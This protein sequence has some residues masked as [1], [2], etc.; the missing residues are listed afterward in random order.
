MAK[1][2]KIDDLLKDLDQVDIWDMADP[3][4]QAFWEEFFQIE[5]ML[6]MSDELDPPRFTV[7][8][9]NHQT[10]TIKTFRNIKLKSVRKKT[11]C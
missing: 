4:D 1:A 11:A 3:S 10:G 2:K 9:E 8:V 5:D 7:T 6:E